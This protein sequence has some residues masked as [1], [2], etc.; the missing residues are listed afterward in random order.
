MT[1]CSAKHLRANGSTGLGFVAL[2]GVSEQQG[3]PVTRASHR[4]TILVVED[5]PDDRVYAEGILRPHYDVEFAADAQEA[6]GKLIGFPPDLVLCDVYMPGEP[7]MDLAE[8]VLTSRKKEIPV[9]MVTGLDDPE[10]ARRA[11]D[12]GCAGYL[13]KP[14]RPDVLLKTV[15]EA[16]GDKHVAFEDTPDEGERQSTR[17]R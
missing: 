9:V 3:D 16:L 2:R 11:S 8:A 6:R 13:A 1:F 5:D 4:P 14:Y 17:S 15:S 7:G 12:L 10:V